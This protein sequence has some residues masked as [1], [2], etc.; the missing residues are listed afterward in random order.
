MLNTINRSSLY[1]DDI[2][3]IIDR[4]K[5]ITCIYIHMFV[6][7]YT[8]MCMHGSFPGSGAICNQFEPFTNH[9]TTNWCAYALLLILFNRR[10][11]IGWII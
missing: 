9:P 1:G 5:Y 6:F 7:M 10:P 8:C 3:A 4:S 11:T 2:A